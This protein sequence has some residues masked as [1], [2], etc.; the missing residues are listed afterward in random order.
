MTLWTELARCLQELRG[1]CR[2]KSTFM[3]LAV[4]LVAWT[5]RPDLLGVTSFVRASFLD[6]RCYPLLLNFFHSNALVLPLLLEAWVRLAMRLFAPLREQG[7]TV[8]VADGLKVPK[9]GKK[10]PAVKCL[11]QESMDNAKAEYVMGH[12]FQ[13]ISLLVTA[14]TGQIFAVPLFSR[15][16][17]GLLWDRPSC[18]RS[19]LDKLADMFGYFRISHQPNCPKSLQAQRRTQPPGD[20]ACTQIAWESAQR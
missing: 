20:P 18:H 13:V 17:E 16:C 10:M 8:F 7:Y 2:R 1:A 4:V 5:V 3:W 6:G 11:H 19:L 9:E 12:S 14:G 15:I